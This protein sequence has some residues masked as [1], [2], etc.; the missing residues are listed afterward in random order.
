M[1]GIYSSQKIRAH[2]LNPLK[3][4]NGKGFPRF[5]ESLS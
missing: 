5:L 2:C 4:L 1:T 3:T